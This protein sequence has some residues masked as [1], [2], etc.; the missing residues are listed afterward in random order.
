MTSLTWR[1]PEPLPKGLDAVSHSVMG[2]WQRHASRFK[3]LEREVKAIDRLAGEY[4]TMTEHNLR[5]KLLECRNQFRR[6]GRIAA[7]QLIPAL[8]AIREAADRTLG[9][10]PFFVQLVGALAL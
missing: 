9:L 2:S 5:Q 3:T 1:E 10:R 6:G 4:A 8:A 7:G